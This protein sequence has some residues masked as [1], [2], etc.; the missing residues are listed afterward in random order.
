MGFPPVLMNSIGINYSIYSKLNFS[1]SG[2]LSYQY[3]GEYL[4]NPMQAA[5]SSVL[6]PRTGQLTTGDL[7]MYEN[8][9]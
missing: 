1:Y 9:K 7:I 5:V 4:L 2:E 6:L 8:V 3:S